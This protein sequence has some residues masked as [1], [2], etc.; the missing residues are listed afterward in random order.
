VG[1]LKFGLGLTLPKIQQWLHNQ[2][3][4]DISTALLW[5]K[6]R[7]S[8]KKYQK[9]LNR[10][11][12]DTDRFAELPW[13]HPDL[14]TL[15]RRLIWHREALYT[16]ITSG[17]PPHNNAAEREIRPAVLM[18]KTSYNN[19]S[20]RGART[21]SVWMSLIRSCRKQDKPIIETAVGY[22]TSA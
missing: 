14:R 22:L 3:N 20:D 18:R 12:H 10:L 9:K 2:Y 16:F 21:Q 7:N 13:Q 8:I 6:R 5:Q 17:I 15:S 19:R 11:I 1:Y 4:L